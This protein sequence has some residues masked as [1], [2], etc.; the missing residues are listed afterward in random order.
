MTEL[1]PEKLLELRRVAA[2][3]MDNWDEDDGYRCL[4]PRYLRLLLPPTVLALLDALT[5]KDAEIA[6]L[7]FENK[8]AL[9]W[10]EVA[11][12]EHCK[13]DMKKGRHQ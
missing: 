9:S 6:Q 5:K 10:V 11:N 7:K 4:P 8:V 12:R 13:R 2:D 3:L 1:T